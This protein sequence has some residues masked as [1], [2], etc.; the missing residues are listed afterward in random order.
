MYLYKPEI[1]DVFKTLFFGDIVYNNDGMRTFVVGAGDG[2]EPL[3][4]GGVPDLQFD[5][6]AADCNGS[7][8]WWCVLESKVDS[9]CG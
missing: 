2:P 5:Y 3:L 6:I 1:L 4:P 7:I 9:N 8:L